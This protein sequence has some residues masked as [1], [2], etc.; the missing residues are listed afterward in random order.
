MFCIYVSCSNRYFCRSDCAEIAVVLACGV[1]DSWC[2]E[3]QGAADA[4]VNWTPL[5][6]RSKEKI[7]K[8]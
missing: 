8:I 5:K 1:L 3:P 7:R 6:S 2:Q 4:D